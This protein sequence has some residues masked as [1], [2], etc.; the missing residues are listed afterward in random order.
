MSILPILV[1]TV[2][3]DY[4]ILVDPGTSEGFPYWINELFVVHLAPNRRGLP[5]EPDRIEYFI[6]CDLERNE[7]PPRIPPTFRDSRRPNGYDPTRRRC[8]WNDPFDGFIKCSYSH[9]SQ[10][11]EVYKRIRVLQPDCANPA[12]AIRIV[13]EPPVAKVVVGNSVTFRAELTTPLRQAHDIRSLNP[14]W[15]GYTLLQD[16]Q[17]G[18][19]ARWVG[20]RATTPSGTIKN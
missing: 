18:E 2:S 4:Q 14:S 19:R 11:F 10:R 8:G 3:R 9:N 20:G 5:D 1:A 15:Q 12:E 13:S 16:R 17:Q 7:I 6:F